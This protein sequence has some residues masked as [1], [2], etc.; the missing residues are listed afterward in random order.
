MTPEQQQELNQHIQAI[1]KIL[2]QE[3]EAEKI[4]TLEGIETTIREQTLKYITP[5]LG[6]FLS[7]KRQELKPGDRE[8]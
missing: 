6:F 8:K 1:A 3:A 7:Q 5:K 4:Q 2:H